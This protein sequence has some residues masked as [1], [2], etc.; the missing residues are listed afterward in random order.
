[1][2]DW[3]THADDLVAAYV[4]GAVSPGEAAVVEQHLA[5]C[6]ECRALERE[7]RAVEAALPALA[8]EAEPPVALKSRVLAAVA[9]GA[10]RA[11]G[12]AAMP[13]DSLAA[14]PQRASE[15]PTPLPLR[16]RTTMGPR[17]ARPWLLLAAAIVIAAAVFAW[18]VTT[19]NSN[20]P[21][22]TYAMAGTTAMRSVSGTLSYYKDGNRLVLD[23]HGLNS[24]PP[25]K[26][27]ELWLI[28]G[29]SVVRGVGVFRPT[30]SGHVHLT[31]T[32]YDV[33]RYTLSGLTVERAPRAQKPTLPIVAAATIAS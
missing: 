7:L 22:K 29:S 24:I 2:I 4:L 30:A 8:G 18:R 11:D 14:R 23:L 26:V 17:R 3:T 21:T 6:A 28:K 13:G 1:M 31:L 32:G 19:L 33:P 12:R 5:G 15:T 27:Y 9:A 16:P 10:S 25:G 20:E